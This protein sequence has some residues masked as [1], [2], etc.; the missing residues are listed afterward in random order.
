[1]ATPGNR[2]RKAGEADLIH[3]VHP[4]G[5]LTEAEPKVTF[6]DLQRTPSPNELAVS[7]RFLVAAGTVGEHS[8]LPTQ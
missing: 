1:M 5:L 8:G 3:P 2:S 6:C 7:T 4:P